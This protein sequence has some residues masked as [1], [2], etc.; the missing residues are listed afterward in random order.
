[1]QRDRKLY[2]GTRQRLFVVILWEGQFQRLLVAGAHADDAIFKACDH[3][4][5]TQLELLA[6]G[7]TAIKGFAVFGAHVIDGDAVFVLRFA[8]HNRPGSTLLAEHVDDVVDVF[9]RHFSL[10]LGNGEVREFYNLYFRE[11]FESRDVFQILACIH[12]ARLDGRLASRLQVFLNHRF[13]E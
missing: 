7:A 4:T 5:G 12:A 11:H 9:A 1:M 3:A 8:L 6:F 10:R 13:L 2:G